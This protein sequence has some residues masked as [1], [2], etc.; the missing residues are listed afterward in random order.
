MSAPP[1]A[2]G[3]RLDCLVI[4]AG[5][6]GL[7]AAIYLA[8]YRHKLLLVDGGPS[9]ATLIPR[10][11]NYPGF[12]EGISGPQLLDRLR[13]QA[14][15]YGVEPVSGWVEDLRATDGL[16]E[17]AIGERRVRARKVLLATGVADELPDMIDWQDAVRC[18]C[19]RLCPVC[20]A[21]EVIDH[22]VAVVASSKHRISS[23]L[24]MRA[25]TRNLTVLTTDPEL[26]LSEAER[27]QLREAKVEFVEEP[28][29]EL[30]KTDRAKA[31]VRTRAGQEL[32]FDCIY[33]MLGARGR[34]ELATR[35]GARANEDGELVVDEHLRTNVPGLYAAGDIVKALNQ[36]SVAVGHAAIA[37]TDI[38][39]SLTR[40]AGG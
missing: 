36:I 39:N 1:H 25:Y 16:F 27:S 19:L 9:R 20:D 31:A 3:E 8:R 18:G 7:T 5:P 4:G 35:L 10:T 33:P 21:F 26:R 30:R 14:Q 11:H 34:S 32:V 28:I 37:A 22:R 2:N 15:H 17:A 38:H 12:P 13:R 6:A 24:F 40:R 29:V 23:A